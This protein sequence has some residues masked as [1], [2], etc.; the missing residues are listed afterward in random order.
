MQLVAAIDDG[1]S[2]GCFAALTLQ[3]LTLLCMLCVL[4]VQV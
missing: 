1:S 3:L 4:Q 2:T